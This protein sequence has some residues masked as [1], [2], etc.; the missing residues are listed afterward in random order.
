MGNKDYNITELQEKLRHTDL[1]VFYFSKEHVILTS[2]K[3]CQDNKIIFQ[4]LF[5]V[6]EIYNIVDLLERE[7]LTEE[8]ITYF[9]LE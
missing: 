3:L 6:S 4:K 9:I 7:L 5:S 8:R 1:K 2:S